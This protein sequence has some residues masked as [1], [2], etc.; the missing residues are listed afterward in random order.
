M[1]HV[2]RLLVC[3][4]SIVKTARLQILLFILVALGGSVFAG[5]REVA[6][7][8]FG[9]RFHRGNIPGIEADSSTNGNMSPSPGF[10]SSTYDDS[11]WQSVDVPH[12]YIVEGT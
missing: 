8:D 4:L 2:S 3:W 1:W 9:W 5:Q 10:L 7:L 12:D 11:S 6:S